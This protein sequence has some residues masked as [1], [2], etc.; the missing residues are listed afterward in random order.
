MKLIFICSVFIFLFSVAACQEAP[1]PAP[2]APP[3]VAST[4]VPAA[5]VLGEM[6]ATPSGV[7]Y[8]DL[9]IGEGQRPLWGQT[10]KVQYVGKLQD[11]K[12]FEKGKYEFKLGDK[13]TLKGFNIG[14]GGGQ[15]IDAM[16]IGGQ[17]VLILPPDLAYGEQGNGK[18]IPPNATLRF[19]IELLEVKGAKAF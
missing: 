15:E 12:I 18:V 9:A 16:K 8:Q 1:A 6:K 14:I 13:D 5:T 7:K 3:V 11:G 2:T 19:E 10:V 4:P 17:R